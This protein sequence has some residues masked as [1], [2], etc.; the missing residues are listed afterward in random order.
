MDNLS[1]ISLPFPKDW[2]FSGCFQRRCTT[3]I[4]ALNVVTYEQRK[5]L[6]RIIRP[7]HKVR[8]SARVQLVQK[9]LLQLW[10]ELARKKLFQHFR[11]S[12]FWWWGPSVMIWRK[13][14]RRSYLA[15]W[16]TWHFTFVSS[17]CTISDTWR[18]LFCSPF[19]TRYFYSTAVQTLTTI[20]DHSYPSYEW[21]SWRQQETYCR[22]DLAK[23]WQF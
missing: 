7:S 3:K 1:C 23:E 22:G 5:L 17:H 14:N 4:K 13:K 19:L 20:H 11:I 16:E 15:D 21:C 18:A 9:Y 12:S 6:L 2:M 8:L 10:L